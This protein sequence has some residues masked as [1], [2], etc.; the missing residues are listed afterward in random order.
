VRKLEAYSKLE[1]QIIA[2]HRSSEHRVLDHD[3]SPGILWLM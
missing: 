1:A 3:S 2:W